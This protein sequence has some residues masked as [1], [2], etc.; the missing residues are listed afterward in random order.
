LSQSDK[1]KNKKQSLE[2]NNVT[3]D[4]GGELVPHNRKQFFPSANFVGRCKVRQAR[5]FLRNANINTVRPTIIR[6]KSRTQGKEK[7]K[8]TQANWHRKKRKY[9]KQSHRNELRP[10]FRRDVV[11]H[12]RKQFFVAE[13]G[14]PHEA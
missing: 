8:K 13:A 10:D 6:K 1:R 7:N 4:F 14:C 2:T 11:P 12:N 3:R 5:Q 9:K